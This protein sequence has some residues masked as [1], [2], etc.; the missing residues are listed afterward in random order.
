MTE[1]LAPITLFCYNR[2]DVLERTVEAL[3][4][5]ILAN[6]SELIIFSDGPKEGQEEKV[7]IVRNFIHTINGFKSIKIFENKK[8]KGLANSI[9]DGVTKVVNEYGKIIVLEDDL[10]TSQY[11]LKYS[12]DFLNLYKDDEKVVS[13][14]AWCFNIK[15]VKEKTFFMKGADCLG[16]ATWKRGWDLFETDGKKLLDEITERNLQEEFEMN[17]SYPYIQMLRQQIEGRVNSW[18]IRWY[19]ST[20]LK[21]KLCLF[22]TKTL[23]AHIGD[24]PDATHCKQN[25]AL[26]EAD[27]DKE[28]SDFPKIEIKENKLMKKRWSEFL[29][30]ARSSQYN[31]KQSVL[32]KFF[33][34]KNENYHG[35]KIKVITILGKMFKI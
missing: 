28:A 23:L 22:P 10:V 30:N 31:K 3:K 24:T 14:S 18:A 9:I 20:F 4:K 7:Q 32:K 1:S 25:G 12:N 26:F 6:E 29:K 17:N 33:S 15:P 11:F 5:N 19:A 13:C 27:I 35:E 8:N 34:V 16:W 2:L 21:N